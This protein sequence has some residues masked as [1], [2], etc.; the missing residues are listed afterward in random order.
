M[1]FSKISGPTWPGQRA[2][3]QGGDVTFRLSRPKLFFARLRDHDLRLDAQRGP[4]HQTRTR[5]G[6]EREGG[7]LGDP[8]GPYGDP[9][10]YLEVNC[11]EVAA[12]SRESTFTFKRGLNV[13]A[14]YST[15]NSNEVVIINWVQ[16][17]GPP[18][19]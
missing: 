4:E 11:Q 3:R 16:Y 17:L 7:S 15:L 5:I 19:P 8:P 2:E 6:R 1:T 18:G 14:D 10:Q 13:K 9:S 12:F